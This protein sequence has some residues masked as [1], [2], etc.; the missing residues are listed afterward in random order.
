VSI[1]VKPDDRA[2][3]TRG[4]V[5]VDFQAVPYRKSGCLQPVVWRVRDGGSGGT[6]FWEAIAEF[7]L[8]LRLKGDVEGKGKRLRRVVVV[9]VGRRTVV[10]RAS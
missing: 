6:V 10:D 3:E 7:V 1:P 5:E 9:I 4:V 2:V 8:P